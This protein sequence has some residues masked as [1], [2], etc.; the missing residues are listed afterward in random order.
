[1]F[2]AIIYTTEVHK[3]KFLFLE[4]TPAMK[5]C[6]QLSAYTN[7]YTHTHRYKY[8]HINT[9][10]HFTT[11]RMLLYQC[12]CKSRIFHLKRY[13][14]FLPMSR[15]FTKSYPI[16]F[17]GGWVFGFTDI[18]QCIQTLPSW[19]A[20]GLS[21]DFSL[22]PKKIVIDP[23]ANTSVYKFLEVILLV[24]GMYIWNTDNAKLPPLKV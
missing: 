14:G 24:Q 18:L 21:P 17:K 16:L 1:M 9:L 7:T 22:L 6:R 11:N 19:W 4:R 5:S 15:I 20:F 8:I 10:N 3:I 13:Y 12:F 23:C 2:L